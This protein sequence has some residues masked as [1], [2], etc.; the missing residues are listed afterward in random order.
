MRNMVK[1]FMK[2]KTILVLFIIFAVASAGISIGRWTVTVVNAEGEMYEELKLFQK[3]FLSS[4]R[5]MS[6][7]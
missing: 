2:K 3:L 6:R 5:T 7:R 1:T 4:E